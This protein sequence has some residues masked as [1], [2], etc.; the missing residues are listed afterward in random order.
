MSAEMDGLV[1]Q[2]EGSM[3]SGLTAIQS[4]RIVEGLRWTALRLFDVL[5]GWAGAAERSDI[6][7]SLATAS[8]HMGW[9]AEDLAALAPD[10][11]LIDADTA[12]PVP[13]GQL[14]SVFDGLSENTDSIENL[15]VAHRVLLARM[16]SRCVSV[17]KVAAANS[18]EPLIRV[19]GF[20][21]TDLRRDRDDG[22][23]LLERLLLD[24][25]IVKKVGSA[26]IEAEGLIVS[27]GGLPPSTV[28]A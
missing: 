12:S 19:I 4:S 21:L 28:P 8:R 2:L 9:H 6:A 18:D 3:Q 14:A 27:A 5:G 24:S 13:S 17:E 16:S 23:A 11:V 15:A 7:V 26:V 1:Q 20:M 22:E 10:S 25:M